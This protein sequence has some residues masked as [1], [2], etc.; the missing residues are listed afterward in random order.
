MSKHIL[1]GCLGL[2]CLAVNPVAAEPPVIRAA[3]VEMPR[4]SSE[5]M[6]WETTPTKMG[7][8]D[9]SGTL[10]GLGAGES[11][12]AYKLEGKYDVLEA[13]IGFLNT[14]PKGRSARFEVTAD[15]LSIYVSEVISS[16]NE[17][18]KVRIPIKGKNYLILG[19]KPQ[20]YGA[21]LGA[22]W[23]DPFIL[24]GVKAEDFPQPVTIEINGKRSQIDPPGGNLPKDLAVPIPLV[25]GTAE[26]RVKVVE[27]N[28]KVIIQVDKATP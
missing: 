7:D 17:P 22:A 8:R 11:R 3:L 5:S 9:V 2:V 23:A 6:L 27:E 26:Y 28:H 4:E 18:L 13:Y 24:G 20:H 12:V 14:V 25:H 16:G 1:L 19:I 21:T 10:Q 15:G